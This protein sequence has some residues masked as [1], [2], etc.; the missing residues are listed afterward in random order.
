MYYMYLGPLHN[1]PI[2]KLLKIINQKTDKSFCIF[3]ILVQWT[4]VNKQQHKNFRTWCMN[5]GIP[6][7]NSEYANGRVVWNPM[8]KQL[9]I[10]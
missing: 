6:G 7:S 8:Y 3:R 4:V 10:V 5:H 2:G 9:D 1:S